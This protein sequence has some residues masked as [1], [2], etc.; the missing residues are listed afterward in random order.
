VTEPD[1]YP[2]MDELRE[3]SML[4]H[5]ERLRRQ[6]D[7]LRARLPLFIRVWL[8]MIGPYGWSPWGRR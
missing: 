8:R 2:S 3:A 7:E 5:F 1:D 4:A 6:L